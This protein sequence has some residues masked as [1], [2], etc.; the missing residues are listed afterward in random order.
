MAESPFKQNLGWIVPKVRVRRTADLW[1]WLIIATH[2]QL[3]L[4]R[5]LRRASAAPGSGWRKLVGS[6]PARGR[7]GLRHIRAKADRRRKALMASHTAVQ[8][9]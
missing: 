8:V 6:P 9:N 4:A 7:R 3:R 5:P 2:T 1:T